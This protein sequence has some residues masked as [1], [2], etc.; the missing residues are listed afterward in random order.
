LVP[1]TAAAF[2]GLARYSYFLSPLFANLR[3]NSAYTI[4]INTT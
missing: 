2:C 1:N 4:V 3:R